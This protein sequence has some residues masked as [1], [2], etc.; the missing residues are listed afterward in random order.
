MSRPLELVI[1]DCDGV[2]V[3]SERLAVRIDVQVLAKLGWTMTE[4]KVIERFLGRSDK[5]IKA[6]IE[7]HLGRSLPDDWDQQFQALYR[8]AFAAELKPV[9]GVVEALAEITLPTCVA[10]SGTHEK[11]RFTL[12]LTG[13]Y[14]RFAGRIFSVYEVDRGKPAP[15]LFLHAATRMGFAPEVCAVIEDS[16]YGIEAARAAGMLAFGFAGGIMPR[17]LL[18]APGVVVFDDMRELPEL[19]ARAAV[20]R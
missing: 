9:P 1:F 3:D 6:D 12:G 18:K 13:L 11:I 19:L 17:A 7:S 2:L 8:A 16:R 10:S 14:E 20:T 4:A 5:S 15:D